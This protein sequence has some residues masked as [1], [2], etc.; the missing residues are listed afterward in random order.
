MRKEKSSVGQGHAGRVGLE[1]ISSVGTFWSFIQLGVLQA[2]SER[3][4]PNKLAIQLLL[5]IIL[6]VSPPTRI[7][8]LLP[9]NAHVE[10]NTRDFI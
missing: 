9:R 6:D 10:A 4:I 5:P 2:E 8:E 1:K 7:P 3:D